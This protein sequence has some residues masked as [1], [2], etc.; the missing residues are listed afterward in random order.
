MLAGGA[1][2]KSTSG[3]VPRRR[4]LPEL[5]ARK[6]S[7]DE[8]PRPRKIAKNPPL[9]DLPDLAL[10]RRTGLAT[11]GGFTTSSADRE[12]PDLARCGG[13]GLST[14]GGVIAL[15]ET[16]PDLALR[17]GI[18]LATAGGFTASSADRTLPGL[19]FCR[20]T[21][22]A[23]AGGFTASSADRTLPDLALGRGT[24]LATAGGFTAPSAQR[25]DERH[26]VVLS[27]GVRVD[28]S[29]SFCELHNPAVLRKTLP[30]WMVVV[31]PVA[32]RVEPED[33]AEHFCP[34]R[35]LPHCQKHG[36]KGK[37]S[38]DQ[39]LGH[40]LMVREVQERCARHLVLAQVQ[41]LLT[42]PPCTLFSSLMASNWT[43]ISLARKMSR[44][45]EGFELFQFAYYTC[46]LQRL[47]GR[48]YVLEHPYRSQGFVQDAIKSLQ[49][50]PNPGRVAVFDQCMFGLVSPRGVPVQKRTKLLTNCE[51]IYTMFH[52]VYCAGAHEHDVCQGSQQGQR[53]SVHCQRY[54]P[55][56]MVAIAQAIANS[57]A[58][59]AKQH[60]R[61]QA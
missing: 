31:R 39:L 11:A 9:P 44:V 30:A 36:L 5:A 43:R 41:Y 61:T 37:Q 60:K 21:R 47:G 40:D 19:A 54:P 12:L 15:S 10:S 26:T 7:L 38:I 14:A 50:P 6:P 55:Q 17:R 48:F 24:D 4:S 52:G 13:T 35:L 23:T 1:I 42:C 46:H 28:V 18:G 25:P 57:K 59:P 2:E 58:K 16:L 22:L 8:K 53:V 20:G 27:T 34:P 3:M 56:M 29:Q 51:S 45:R 33:V 32:D 49:E